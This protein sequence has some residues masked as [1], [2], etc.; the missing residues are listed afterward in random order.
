[1]ASRSLR[2]LTVV[3]PCAVLSATLLVGCGFDSASTNKSTPNSVVCTRIA[4]V[5]SDGPDAD[6]DP[7]GHAEA[8]I[9]PLRAIHPS[10]AALRSALE[11]LDAAFRTFYQSNGSRGSHAITV[12]SANLNRI[13]PGAT[14]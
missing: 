8:Q 11:Q 13:C 12:A 4:A 6:S 5:L 3:V 2:S 1:M 14:S 10:S 7:I 9:L